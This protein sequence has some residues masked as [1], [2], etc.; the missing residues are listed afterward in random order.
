MHGRSTM[1]PENTKLCASC[2]R[3][4]SFYVQF[5]TPT[6][7]ELLRKN[8]N[9]LDK[10]AAKGCE[11]C[12]LQKRMFTNSEYA[13]IDPIENPTYGFNRLVWACREDLELIVA[14]PTRGN[15]SSIVKH[16]RMVSESG[17]SS[18]HN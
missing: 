7:S 13:Q 6:N 17:K 16:V 18:N 1:K 2:N 10:A 11:L 9:E 5:K 12:R 8:L 4:L 3:L 14:Y 15:A